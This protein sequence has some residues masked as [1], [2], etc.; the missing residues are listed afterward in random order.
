MA[1]GSITKIIQGSVRLKLVLTAYQ[2]NLDV[3]YTMKIEVG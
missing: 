2:F 3:F 1:I